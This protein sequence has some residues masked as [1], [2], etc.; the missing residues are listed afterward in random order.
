MIHFDDMHN[1]EKYDKV[2]RVLPSN[3]KYSRDIS[4][5]KLQRNPSNIFICTKLQ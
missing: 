2:Q 3:K 1:T 4:K 5:K